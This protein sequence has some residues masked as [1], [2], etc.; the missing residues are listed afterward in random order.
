MT[1]GST[2]GGGP[3]GLIVQNASYIRRE[4]DKLRTELAG[5][6]VAVSDFGQ[7]LQELNGRH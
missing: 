6:Y 2:G 4:M 5:S 7:Y 3:A 1:R